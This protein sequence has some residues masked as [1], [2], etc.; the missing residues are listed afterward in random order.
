[1]K[2]G[3]IGVEKQKVNQGRNKIHHGECVGQRGHRERTEI[4]TK[5]RGKGKEHKKILVEILPQ[6]F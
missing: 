3:Q 5:E 6:D 4:T 1:M 2:V